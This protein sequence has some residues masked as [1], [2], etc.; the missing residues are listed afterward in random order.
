MPWIEQINPDTMQPQ[1][2]MLETDPFDGSTYFSEVRTTPPTGD[3]SNNTMLFGS[4][5]KAIELANQAAQ[6]LG[7]TVPEWTKYA[8]G[9]ISRDNI[10]G[11]KG[12]MLGAPDALVANSLLRELSFDPQYASVFNAMTP[13]QLQQIR[14]SSGPQGQGYYDPSGQVWQQTTA[15]GDARE[16][17]LRAMEE[18]NG[19]T[20]QWL[21]ALGPIAAFAGPSILSNL[22]GSGSGALSAIDAAQFGTAA[23]P[24]S[25]GGGGSL[26]QLAQYADAGK[27]LLDSGSFAN[28]I[29]ANAAPAPA[30]AIEALIN[31]SNAAGTTATPAAAGLGFASPEAYI[32]SL[33]PAWAAI[34]AAAAGA[35][36]GGAAAPSLGTLASGAG[37]ATTAAGAL[38]G[39]NTE[40]QDLL[41]PG[42][43]ASGVTTPNTSGGDPDLPGIGQPGWESLP[44]STPYGT[45]TIPASLWSRLLDGT[46]SAD[47]YMNLLGKAAPGL[48]GAYA[49]SQ[50][51]NALVDLARSQQE[52]ENARYQDLV[53]R[54]ER[55]YQTALQRENEAIAKR[56]AALAEFRGYGAPYRSRLSELSAD[57]SSFLSSAEV[58]TPVQQ[59]TD[60]MARALSAKVGNPIGSGGALQELQNYA[61]NSLFGRLGQEKDRL[62]GFG[63][64]SQFNT[65]GAGIPGLSTTL[66]TGTNSGSGVGTGGGNQAE[67]AALGSNANIYNSLGYGLD[68]VLNPKTSLADLLKQYGGGLSLV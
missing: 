39:D 22:L 8:E 63:G 31:A 3:N 16:Q 49:S 53:G 17:A 4:G 62:A 7:I 66:P 46:A 68:Q 43:E 13:T 33:N 64:L 9:I 1:W 59:G 27:T 51:N 67:T 38:G 56:D 20:G 47:E 23:A 35:A 32:A 5:G 36:V 21:G 55:R 34:P 65:S 15:A 48:L 45:S 10:N 50:Q 37:L 14:N 18:T 25:I 28:E 44:G 61:T 42:D 41:Y 12:W 19:S 54:D 29:A 2:A 58:T 24:V 26:A 6:Q 57:P 30:D 40:I 60:I 11:G 52:A